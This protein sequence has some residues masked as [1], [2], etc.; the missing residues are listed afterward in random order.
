MRGEIIVE[1]QEEF[2]AWFAGKKS[3]YYV[4]NP[5]KD[6]AMQKATDSVKVVAAIQQK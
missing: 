5:E 1:S 2:D 3:Q 4:A 6:P